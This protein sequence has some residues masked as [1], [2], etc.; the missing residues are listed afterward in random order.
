NDL[1]KLDIDLKEVTQQ[2]EDEGVEKF[3]K[4]F[5][6]LMD[7]LE[8]QREEA[9]SLPVDKIK[10]NL[11]ALETDVEKRLQSMA[12]Y[13][14]N[15]RIWNKDPLLWKD[16]EDSKQ[17]I[18]NAM[19]WLDV[20]GKMARVVPQLQHFARKL[21]EEGFTHVVRMGMGGRRLGPRRLARI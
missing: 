20:A 11:G 4:P 10:V 14:F 7:V 8:N 18:P 21:R 17:M 6:K 15:E 19:G 1:P 3:N 9:L 16:D 12:E 2:L 13:H 5:D